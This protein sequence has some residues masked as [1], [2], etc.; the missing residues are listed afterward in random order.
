MVVIDAD[1]LKWTFSRA[2]LDAVTLMKRHD[3]PRTLLIA[4]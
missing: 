4:V 2:E 3:R 1:H